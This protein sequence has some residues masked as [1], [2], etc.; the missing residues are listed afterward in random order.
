MKGFRDKKVELETT[1]AKA[2]SDYERRTPCIICALYYCELLLLSMQL[3][4][5]A[6][7][8]IEELSAIVQVFGSER[9][10]VVEAYA[11]SG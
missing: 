11:R 5:A 9:S 1:E 3:V 7:H 8:D 10:A 4:L 2:V 6:T